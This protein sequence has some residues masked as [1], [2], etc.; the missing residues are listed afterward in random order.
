[1][2]YILGRISGKCTAV[3]PGDWP[4]QTS[5]RMGGQGLTQIKRRGLYFHCLYFLSI[6]YRNKQ[7]EPT[8][9]CFQPCH[10]EILNINKRN[11]TI[12]TSYTHDSIKLHLYHFMVW[13]DHF[14]TSLLTY[15]RHLFLNFS[16]SNM[17]PLTSIYMAQEC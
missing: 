14:C 1:M 9:N 6:L 10:M 8:F 16:R 13:K 4:L 5:G 7:I 15:F 12:S 11:S 2:E 17:I 3:C